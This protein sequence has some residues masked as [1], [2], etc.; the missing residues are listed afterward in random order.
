MKL[1]EDQRETLVNEDQGDRMETMVLKDRLDQRETLVIKDRLDQG[2]IREIR[3]IR[4]T[5]DLEELPVMLLGL[6]LAHPLL[7]QVKRLVLEQLT[8]R[9]NYIYLQEHQEIVN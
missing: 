7:Y 1:L 2:E 4:E 8:H 3:E 5:Q 6:L 9:E